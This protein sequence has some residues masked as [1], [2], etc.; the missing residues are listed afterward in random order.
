MNKL[1]KQIRESFFNPVFQLLPILV[2]LVIDEIFGMN[3][4]WKT[5]FPV[6]MILLVYVFY[7]YNRIFTWHLIFTS[8]FLVISLIAGVEYFFPITANFHQ[9]LY[10]LVVMS[11]LIVFIV[12]RKP[13]QRIISRIISR[14]IPMTNNYNELYRFLYILLAILTLY[15]SAVVLL[16]SEKGKD[17]YLC[18]QS[19][20]YIYIGS[21]VFL[22]LYEI[23]RVHIIRTDLMKEEWW[24]IV[25]EQGKIIGSINHLTSLNDKNKYR[26]PVVRV[27]LI[28]KGMILMQKRSAENLIFPGLWDTAISN[29]VK[30]EET[31]DQCIVRTAKDRYGLDNFKHMYL[32]NYTI[33][34][35]NEL[36]YAFLFVSC[37]QMDIKPNI[38]L[39][40]QTKWWTQKQIE[41]N[42]NS[43]IFTESFKMEYNLLKRSG[44]LE[45]EK[46]ECECRLKDTVYKTK[47]D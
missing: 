4:A 33:E 20:Q 47:K 15:V 32:A 38:L 40:D 17:M 46:C 18:L 45:S 30:M 24:P 43:G 23:L 21:L 5:S 13:V 19:T 16:R 41:E 9:I 28:E 25:S 11:F 37:Q 42:L 7:V 1:R 31:V 10:E 34:V 35:E 22:I 39:I 26:H 29:H 3:I 2:F 6:A 27:L 36:Q 44:L 8:I 12:F 14:L